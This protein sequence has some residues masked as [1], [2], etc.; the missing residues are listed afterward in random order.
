MRIRWLRITY[1]RSRGGRE[2][3][4]NKVRR[5]RIEA[6]RVG[7]QGQGFSFPLLA[8]PIV[9][10]QIHGIL[11]GRRDAMQCNARGVKRVHARTGSIQT[12]TRDDG[13]RRRGGVEGRGG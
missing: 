8:A 5:S 11:G 7:V 10:R 3:A 1:L 12:P 4:G 6:K 13:G 9:D 2:S